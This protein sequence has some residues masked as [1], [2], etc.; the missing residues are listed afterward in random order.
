MS[1][2]VKGAGMSLRAGDRGFLPA[3]M[4]VVLGY[5]QWKIQCRRKIEPKEIPSCLIP[6]LLVLFTRQLEI[7]VTALGRP[8]HSV[9]HVLKRGLKSS[10]KDQ[11]VWLFG[12]TIVGAGLRIVAMEAQ[13]A[14]ECNVKSNSRV[15]S[16]T[17]IIALKWDE[18]ENIR[19]GGAKKVKI[20][21]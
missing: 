20:T 16:M 4:N 10:C 17:A 9:V 2:N 15:N 5:F 13:S 21:S 8:I 7:L 12:M 6:H 18:R 3:T 19:S 1:Y 14:L 11:P